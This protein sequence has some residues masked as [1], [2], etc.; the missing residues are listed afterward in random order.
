MNVEIQIQVSAGG[1]FVN[2]SR[3][4]SA[5]GLI[6]AEPVLNL[7][8]PVS[9][10]VKT[11]ANTAAGNLAGGHGQTTGVFDVYWD[12]GRRYGVT[13]TITTNALALDGGDGDD[14]PDSANATV[15][16]CKQKQI[17]AAVD[18]DALGVFVLNL[19]F[20]D[21]EIDSVGHATFKDAAGDVIAEI[22]LDANVT[23]LWNIEAG[24][25]NPFTG[26][27]VVAVYASQANQST[28]PTLQIV[29]AVDV[30]P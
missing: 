19:K 13:V 17:N 20:D 10:W 11:D 25:T 28:A 18:G 26:D 29:G 15:A 12:G 27:P 6:A 8:F 7:A 30:T 16:V 2:E 9:D 22:D 5:D 21:K 24:Q 23:Q 1:I 14:F 4:I 3:V